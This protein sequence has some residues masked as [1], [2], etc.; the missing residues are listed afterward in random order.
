[1]FMPRLAALRQSFGWSQMTVAQK[2]GVS[3]QTVSN[4]E[5]GYAQPSVEMVIALAEI[6]DVSTDYIL[7]RESGRSINVEGLPDE[8]VA[9]FTALMEDYRMS[10]QL[11]T[12]ENPPSS[13]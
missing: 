4:W 3:K 12:P 10:Q 2:L 13:A 1:M 8:I 11:V 9:H 7:G 5:N 6:F